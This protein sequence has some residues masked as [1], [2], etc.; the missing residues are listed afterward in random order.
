MTW[1]LMPAV[2]ELGTGER[3]PAER[4]NDR[5]MRFTTAEGR[6]GRSDVGEGSERVRLA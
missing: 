6:Q 2:V 1:R 3:C 5:A 4:C